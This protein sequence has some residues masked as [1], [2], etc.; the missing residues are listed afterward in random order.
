MRKLLA[1]CVISGVGA[2][3]AP[4]EGRASDPG[5]FGFTINASLTMKAQDLRIA[6]D[7]VEAS[8]DLANETGADVSTLLAFRLPRLTGADADA[9]EALPN[10]DDPVNFVNFS[11][12]ADGAPV[13]A[14]I[15]QRASI[16]GVDLND[17]LKADGVPLNPYAKGAGREA[18]G[19]LPKEKR[20][21]YLSHGLAQWSEGQPISVQWDVATAHSWIQTVPAGKSVRIIVRYVPLATST[22]L[23][24]DLVAAT[25][26]DGV[27]RR[28]CL[29]DQAV[30]AL[31]KLSKH[32]AREDAAAPLVGVT[33]DYG[34]LSSL[35]W[36]Q[37]IG[38]Y[39]LAVVKPRGG[40]AGSCALGAGAA[41]GRDEIRVT[42]KNFSPASDISV[43]FVGGAGEK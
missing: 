1:I 42:R 8:Y 30:S 20:G 26:P 40:L 25:G 19:R 5:G 15:E 21:F 34:L 35:G 32:G 7:K 36:S 27:R 33:V 38:A 13:R 3:G 37:E 41:D 23:S 12:T 4:S 18:L 31:D 43:L 24:A 17:R 28:F 29:T 6:A 11:A 10:P 39:S 22:L 14:T 16:L 9:V 2:L